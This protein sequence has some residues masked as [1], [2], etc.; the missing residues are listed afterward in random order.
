MGFLVNVGRAS[1]VRLYG[2]ALVEAGQDRARLRSQRAPAPSRQALADAGAEAMQVSLDVELVVLA[3]KLEESSLPPTPEKLWQRSEPTLRPKAEGKYGLVEAPSLGWSVGMHKAGVSVDQ[4][5]QW[6]SSPRCRRRNSR[7]LSPI[8]SA[9]IY[10]N[11]QGVGDLGP[12][13]RPSV[14]I[15]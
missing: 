14:V 6:E 7:L 1:F 15:S 5:K 10:Q 8:L 13:D 12:V 3:E 11:A 4:A 2:R 9:T